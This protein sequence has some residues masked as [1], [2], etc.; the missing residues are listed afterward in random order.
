VEKRLLD[1][2]GNPNFGLNFYILNTR[3]DCAAV[4]L[5]AST[6]AICTENGAE[7]LETEPLLEGSPTD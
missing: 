2:R 6:F 7:I 3:G 5:S 4:S 1:A